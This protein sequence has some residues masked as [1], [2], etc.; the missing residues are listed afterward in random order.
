MNIHRIVETGLKC[1]FHIHSKYSSFREKDKITKENLN[2]N[3][4][5]VQKLINALVKNEIE[6]AAITDHDVFSF[7]FYKELKKAEGMGK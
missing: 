2:K 1:D 6:I 3:N 4:D 5:D 7:A